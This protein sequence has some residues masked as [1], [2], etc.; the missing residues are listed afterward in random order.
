MKAIVASKPN[1]QK[2]ESHLNDYENNTMAYNRRKEIRAQQN[3]AQGMMRRKKTLMMN[4]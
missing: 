1:V 4:I 3:L 2:A